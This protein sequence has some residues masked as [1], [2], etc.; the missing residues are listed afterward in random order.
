MQKSKP[1]KNSTVVN[2]S[3]IQRALEND[4]S[5][6]SSKIIGKQNIGLPQES[7]ESS[8]S[9]VPSLAS[10]SSS[11]PQTEAIDMGT[12]SLS[13]L[14]AVPQVDLSRQGPQLQLGMLGVGGY[15]TTS[16]EL[17]WG[18]D[19]PAYN[20]IPP[21]TDT[22]TDQPAKA[23]CCAVS[24]PI[25]SEP[26]PAISTGGSCCAG[27]KSRH[28]APP[29]SPAHKNHFFAHPHH[30]DVVMNHP[31]AGTS[32]MFPLPDAT[33]APQPFSSVPFAEDQFGCLHE[34]DHSCQCG[35]GCECLG[36]SLHPAN[37]TTTDYVRYHMELAMQGW[38][39]TAL[40]SVPASYNPALIPGTFTLNESLPD[41]ND[42]RVASFTQNNP[43]TMSN[44]YGPQFMPQWHIDTPQTSTPSDE[45][46]QFTLQHSLPS[47]TAPT[48]ARPRRPRT[49]PQ[50]ALG[51][52][53]PSSRSHARQLSLNDT[54]IYDHDSPSTEDDTSTLS[55]SAFSV[56]QYKIPG[57]NDATGSCLCGDGCRCEGC[58]THNG[59]NN[60]LAS[61][62]ESGV[63]PENVPDLQKASASVLA[64][65]GVDDVQHASS[66]QL[67]GNG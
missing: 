55:P 2:S 62:T 24:A 58:L 17:G 49:P 50:S 39:N 29:T 59:H 67:I 54:R 27:K 46:S 14:P 20:D 36:C 19:W 21:A 32:G 37:R 8:S 56:Q 45:M 25:T 35:E 53:H 66:C 13:G 15:G 3:T 64:R 43:Y 18:G 33:F 52:R 47:T 10:S 30:A 41:F 1:R 12:R 4:L 7:S 42:L 60:E 11:T 22:V 16:D 34:P 23:S 51:F 5:A 9:T 40:Y 48:E 63:A 44:V 28:M 61:D 57:C 26:E 65:N 38:T 31:N 6:P